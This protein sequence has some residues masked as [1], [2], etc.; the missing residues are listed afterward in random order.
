MR[1]LRIYGILGLVAAH[2]SEEDCRSPGTQLLQASAQARRPK[3]RWQ[4]GRGNFP[5]FAVSEDTG[6]FNLNETLAWS[7]HHPQGRFH[8]LTYGTAVDHKMNFYLSAADG[9]R[10][11]DE[12]GK[13][14][15]EHNVLPRNLMNAPSLYQGAVYASDTD[16]G[17]L[18]VDMESGKPL[19]YT[20][21]LKPT[22]QDNGFTMVHE[23]VVFAANDYREPSPQGPANHMVQA[24]NASSGQ[25]LWSYE[26]DMPVWNF[27]PLFPD[28]AAWIQGSSRLV[29]CW[30]RSEETL[31]FQ[32]MSGKV[33]RMSLK[34]KLLWKAGG[35]EGTWTD[36]GAALGDKMV[37][38]QLFF[39]A[40]RA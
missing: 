18:A 32:D 21:T 35:T 7:W 38:R 30:K 19:W 4:S 33:Y 2:C 36:G 34:G 23:G 3:Y 14:L 22:G 39:R 15:W 24:L 9:L 1:V 26:P 28:K 8:T 10:K 17:V 5:N 6:P 29:S 40:S 16:G 37:P 31:V 11:F 25:V 27:L 20:K 12:H 13:M